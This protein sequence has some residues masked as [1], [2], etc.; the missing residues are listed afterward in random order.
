MWLGLISFFFTQPRFTCR[1]RTRRLDLASVPPSF[2]ASM[3]S[4]ALVAI[5][6]LTKWQLHYRTITPSNGGTSRSN[7]RCHSLMVRWFDGFNR[8]GSSAVA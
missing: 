8:F 5:C 4:S 7:S 1:E 2:S 3:F 6:F